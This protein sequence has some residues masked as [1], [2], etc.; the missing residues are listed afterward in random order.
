MAVQF[1]LKIQPDKA[2]PF[3]KGVNLR[4]FMLL[5]DEFI[6]RLLLIQIYMYIHTFSFVA[7]RVLV[8]IS[9]EMDTRQ[10]G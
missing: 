9:Q 4:Y 10:R 5:T 7:A 6:I 2:M 1:I 3:V 8:D